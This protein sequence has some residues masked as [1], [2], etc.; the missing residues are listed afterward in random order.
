MIEE[1]K[2]YYPAMIEKNR[3]MPIIIGDRWAGFITFYIT[4]N[5]HE[6][7]DKDPWGIFEDNPNGSICYISQMMTDKHSDNKNFSFR[8][9]NNFKTF[10]KNKFPNVKYIFWRRWD[11]NK[12]IVKVYK[13]EL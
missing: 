5:E 3:V 12:N 10:I 13:K 2:K 8:A 9:L 1:R 6:Y 11:K 4:N 7:D